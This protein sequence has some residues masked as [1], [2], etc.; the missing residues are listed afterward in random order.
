MEPLEGIGWVDDV[1][2]EKAREFKDFEKTRVE[3]RPSKVAVE[4]FGSD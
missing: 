4:L 2:A 1:M 3:V